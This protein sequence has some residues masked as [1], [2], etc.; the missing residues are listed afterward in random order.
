MADYLPP[1]VVDLVANIGDFM[2]K[3]DRAIGKVKQFGDQSASASVGLDG[4]KTIIRQLD[5]MQAR[6]ERF[7]FTKK[8]ALLGLK[9]GELVALEL[10]KLQGNLREF[11]RTHAVADVK[12]DGITAALVEVSALKWEINHLSSSGASI[13]PSLMSMIPKGGG[14][15]ETMQAIINRATVNTNQ[16]ETSN[17]GILAR[18]LG[19]M[20]GGTGGGMLSFTRAG[21]SGGGPLGMLSPL[22]ITG[23]VAAVA[24]LLAILPP[25]IGLVGGLATAFGAAAMGAGAFGAVAFTAISEALKG[26]AGMDPWLKSLRTK[27]LAGETAFTAFWDKVTKMEVPT[28]SKIVGQWVSVGVKIL[29]DFM[30]LFKAGGVGME[31]FT[32]NLTPAF[33]NP[34]FKGFIGQMAKAAPGVMGAGG[35][36][37]GNLGEGLANIG[38][39][40]LPMVPLVDKGFV[41][42]TASFKKWAMSLEKSKGF[43]QFLKAAEKGFPLIGKLIG[44][45][46]ALLGIIISLAIQLGEIMGPVLAFEVQMFGRLFGAIGKV[47]GPIAAVVLG[48]LKTKLGAA[49][50]S[51][52]LLGLG[53]AFVLMGIRAAIAWVMALS[54]IALIVIGIGLLIAIVV[55]VITH[56]KQVG[57][58]FAG[59]WKGITTGVG[60]VISFITSHWG[61]VASMLEAP[62]TLALGVIGGIYNQIKS[63]IGDI[64]G[65]LGSHPSG[66]HPSGA[67]SVLPQL[68][69]GRFGSGVTIGNGTS[70]AA[71]GGT[72]LHV[73]NSIVIQGNASPSSVAQIKAVLAEW[74]RGLVQTLGAA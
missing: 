35:K 37:L 43:Q 45:V 30:P 39:A 4:E 21:Q 60:D 6:L 72:P 59:L 56:W 63:W 53:I 11:A 68:A 25:V 70:N 40:F 28:I 50:L 12:I 24:P 66:S 41:S 16:G 14:F 74:E 7:G 51:T 17:N 71:L 44:G 22:A 19:S 27:L 9:N 54:P 2:T 8:S 26:G 57:T 13:P 31:A 69:G 20:A 64:T 48:F 55:V 36:G 58:F 33:T 10:D 46:V 18:V 42:M 47:V 73:S 15:S 61:I 5:D 52:V 34:A 23:I 3:M 32:K 38:Q 49:I 67:T 62:F 29:P 1:A 65:F